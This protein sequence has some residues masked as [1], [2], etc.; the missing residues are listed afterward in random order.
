M[1]NPTREQQTRD[2]TKRKQSWQP[3][4]L[5]PVPDPQNGVKYRWVRVGSRSGNADTQ[6]VSKRFREGWTPVNAKDHPEL[7]VMTDRN[8]EFT[9]G[10]E[11]GGLLLCKTAE[12]NVRER[13]EYY[14]TVARNQMTSV[15][16]NFFRENDPRMPTLKKESRT[17][18]TFGN[19]GE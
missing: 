12:E 11:V 9:E 19:G 6:N 8:S 15:D 18:T 13:N 4:A 3:A 16:N 1:A 5:L 7:N 14:G 10:V 2:A 17:R